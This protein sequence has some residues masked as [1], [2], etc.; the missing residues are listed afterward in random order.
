MATKH[1]RRT[2][3]GAT[4]RTVSDTLFMLS[5]GAHC[6]PALAEATGLMPATISKWIR[7]WLRPHAQ[8]IHVA[9]WKPIPAILRGMTYFRYLPE[10]KLGVAPDAPHPLNN[11]R[12][13]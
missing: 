1:S 2:P 5:Q 7:V 11:N 13:L 4:Q 9:S 6:V 8:L 12:E 10:Y 3:L